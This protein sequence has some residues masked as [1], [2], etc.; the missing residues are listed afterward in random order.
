MHYALKERIEIGCRVFTHSLTKEEAA[1]EYDV[2]IPCIVEYSN[3]W[4][5][6]V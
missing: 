2:T 4:E 6:S 1:K 3:A 5:L